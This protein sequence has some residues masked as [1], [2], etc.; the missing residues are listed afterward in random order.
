ML[1]LQKF[2]DRIRGHEARGAKDFIMPM[3]DA[4]GMAADLTQLL[5]ELKTYQ[6]QAIAGKEEEIIEVNINGGSF[7]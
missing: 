7:K 2:I 4:K 1:H 6:E 5:L 3:I